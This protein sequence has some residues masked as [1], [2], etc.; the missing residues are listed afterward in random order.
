MEN[1]AGGNALKSKRVCLAVFS[2]TGNTLTVAQSLAEALRELGR[3]VRL[4]PMESG[5]P[6]VCEPGAAVGIAT[7]VACF[8]TYP[9][10]WR[11]IDSLPPGE[12]R[13]AFFLATMGGAGGGMQGPV[14]RVVENKGYKPVGSLIVA[15]PGNYANKTVDVAKNKKL[16]EKAARSAKKFAAD[17][18]GGESKCPEGI[19]A[20]SNFFAYLAHGRHPWNFFGRLFPLSVDR[21][22]C[23]GCGVCETLCPEG[24]IKVTG[25]KASLGENCESCQRCAAFCHANAVHVRGRP[26]VQYRG[27]TLESIMEFK[28]SKCCL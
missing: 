14:R 28:N 7:T 8:S 25:K 10:A 26:Y 11:F 2:G 16:E 21:G 20:M 3:D 5:E 22:K 9:T 13:E 15:M 6:F 27:T 12:G 24:N 18:A 1:S 23:D 17:L 4:F 19:P